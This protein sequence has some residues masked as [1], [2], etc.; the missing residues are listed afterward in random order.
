[1]TETE[2]GMALTRTDGTAAAFALVFLALLGGESRLVLE[3]RGFAS[4]S[5]TH[6]DSSAAFE[7]H[8]PSAATVPCGVPIA[9]RADVAVAEATSPAQLARR[10]ENPFID[11]GAHQAYFAG[12]YAALQPWVAAER[13]AAAPQTDTDL[14]NR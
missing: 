1:M 13:E 9:A 14:E 5:A 2:T 8:R 7:P 3:E 6:C 10:D 12:A 4:D 11:S